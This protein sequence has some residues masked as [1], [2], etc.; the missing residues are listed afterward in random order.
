MT[1]K[2]AK[3]IW[4][5]LKE[6]E[7]DEKIKGMQMLNLIEDFE[8]QRMK[9]SET[10]QEYSNRLLEI[11]N[12][13]R[14]LGGE[15]ADTRLV[16]KLLVLVPERFETTISALENTKGSVKVNFS[17]TLECFSST[18]AKKI[19]EAGRND[20]GSNVSKVSTKTK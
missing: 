12:K 2:T 13:V 9:E 8:L 7:G 18:R 4:D 17:R 15:F 14:L 3:D 20:R 1:L 19:Y 11:A 16:Q 5:F 6:Y 10:I